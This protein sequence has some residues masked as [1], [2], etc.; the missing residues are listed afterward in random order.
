MNKWKWIVVIESF[1][2]VALVLFLIFHHEDRFTPL[3]NHEG[4]GWYMMVDHRTGTVCFG[5]PV[6]PYEPDFIPAG[7]TPETLPADFFEKKG[8]YEK[9]YKGTGMPYCKD[10]R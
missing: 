2:V 6:R 9:S 7:K 8:A 10:L 5:G 4:D 3:G 1:V